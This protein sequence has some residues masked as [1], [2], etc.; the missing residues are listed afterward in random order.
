MVKLKPEEDAHGQGMWAY[1][2]GE[3]SFEIVERDD[4]YFDALPGAKAYFLRYEDWIL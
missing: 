4:G 2:N 3:E 1:Y